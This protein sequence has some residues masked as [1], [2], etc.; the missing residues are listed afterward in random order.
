M[1]KCR[2]LPVILAAALLTGCAG[3]DTTNID[4]IIEA[5]NTTAAPETTAAPPEP[6]TDAPLDAANDG[7][8]VDLT[9]L[10]SNMV[11]AQVYDMVYRPEEYE[12]KTV[13]ARGNFA[14]YQDETTHKE[15]FAVLISDAT[16]CCAQGIEFVRKGEYLFPDD[17]PEE[18]T[19]ITIAGEFFSYVEDSV[20]YV[21]LRNA[22]ILT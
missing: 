9:I 18:G 1:R 5:E 17:Y 20:T 19:E 12:G 14:Y 2:I 8:D 7:Y 16:A 11:Y 6:V 4:R 22:E 21:Q 3:A 15:Y 13:R 10:D